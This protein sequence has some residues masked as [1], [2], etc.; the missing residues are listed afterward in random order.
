MARHIPNNDLAG[1]DRQRRR[2]HG[3]ELIGG[4]DEAGRGCLAGPVVAACAVLGTGTR[5]PGVDDSKELTASRREALVPLILAKAVAWGVG[6][7]DP[8]EIDRV[9]ILQATHLAAGRAMARL[10][11][12]PQW[13]LTDYLKLEGAPC[14]VEPV[15]DGD[16]KSLAIAAA[17]VLAKVARDRIMVL[18]DAE[19]PQYGL[20]GHKGYGSKSHR[21]AIDRHGPSTLHRLTFRGVAPEPFFGEEAAPGPRVFALSRGRLPGLVRRDPDFAALLAGDPTAMDPWLYL[22]E[23]EWAAQDRA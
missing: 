22:P 19:Y 2:R 5:L 4:V 16:A 9:N 1:F 21:Q 3:V 12:Q 10:A 17:S 11:M 20:A 18:L 8:A 13:L 7:S 6:W 14:P 15:T 23:A